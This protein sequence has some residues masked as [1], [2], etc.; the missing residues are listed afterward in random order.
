MDADVE[1]ITEE[2]ETKCAE[3]LWAHIEA[4]KDEV[5]DLA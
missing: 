3:D 1:G 2:E 5:E 4:H